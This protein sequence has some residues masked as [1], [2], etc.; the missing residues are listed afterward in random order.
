MGNYKIGSTTLNTGPFG[1]KLGLIEA[2]KIGG[3]AGTTHRLSS[4]LDPEKNGILFS[5]PTPLTNRDTHRPTKEATTQNHVT[6]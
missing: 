5:S 3:F 2:E 1:I 6:S 4:A